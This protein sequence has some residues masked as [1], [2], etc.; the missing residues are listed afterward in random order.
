MEKPTL[1]ISMT[2]REFDTLLHFAEAYL[3][4][5][6]DVPEMQLLSRILNDK[7][8]KLI[9]RSLYSQYKSTTCTAEEREAARKEYI[10]RKNIPSDFRW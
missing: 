6:P 4:V 8:D 3:E 7:L 5:N 10:D 2:L 1:Q 9:N